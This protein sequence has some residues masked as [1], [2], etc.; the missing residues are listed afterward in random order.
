MFTIAIGVLFQKLM[1][2]H[3]PLLSGLQPPTLSMDGVLMCIGENLYRF[4]M[5]TIAIG[6]LFLILDVRMVL[7][8][9]TTACI[10]FHQQRCNLLL[11][12]CLV[13]HQSSKVRIMDV[14]QQSNGSDCG[15][16]AIAFAFDICCGK[17]PCSVR[18]D[19]KSIRHHLAKCLENCQ[20]TRFSILGECKSLVS[21]MFKRLN[22][23]V[24]VDFR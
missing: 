7:L 5:F 11:L 15:V 2:Q 18:V 24:L 13:Q 20:F 4:L 22:F 23:T 14:G 12:L 16:L 6:V 19:H 8:I 9:T 10:L 17:D 3:F 1:L 21:S